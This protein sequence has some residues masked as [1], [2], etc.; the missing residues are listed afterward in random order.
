MQLGT[1]S[2]Y[3]VYFYKSMLCFWTF[4]GEIQQM[5]YQ[6]NDI[7]SRPNERFMI[8]QKTEKESGDGK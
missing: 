7:P 5:E 6:E 1:I 2:F 8:E 3:E 4:V